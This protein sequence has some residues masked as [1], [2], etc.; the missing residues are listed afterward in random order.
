MINAQ[1]APCDRHVLSMVGSSVSGR[2]QGTGVT[3][4]PNHGQL[5]LSIPSRPLD[6]PGLVLIL[7][8]PLRGR[9]CIQA[10]PQAG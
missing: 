5:A 1:R 2:P 8:M 9:S 10:R 7:P 6:E 3:P 4:A